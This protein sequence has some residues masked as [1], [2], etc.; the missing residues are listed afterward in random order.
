[1]RPDSPLPDSPPEPHPTARLDRLQS[2]S[3][4]LDN[5]IAIPGTPYR[6]GLDPIIGLLPGG[7][8]TVT[9]LLSAYLV[10]E[11][12]RLG[13][14]RATLVRMVWNILLEVI[15]G[16]I[17]VVGDLF[18]FAWKANSKNM[19]LIRQHLDLPHRSRRRDRGFAILLIAFLLVVILGLVSF[20]VW[21]FSLVLQA[22][23]GN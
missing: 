1:M 12:A 14:P 4:W 21:L 10:W 22:L 23:G 3:Y 16:T 7:G 6:F 2:F 18:D 9:G 17:P 11:A 19:R 8:D 20:S 13:L 5:A 15:V